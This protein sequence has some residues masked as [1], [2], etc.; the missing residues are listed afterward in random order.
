VTAIE[1]MTLALGMLLVSF[2]YGCAL[3]FVFKRHALK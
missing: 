2:I 1:A 3:S